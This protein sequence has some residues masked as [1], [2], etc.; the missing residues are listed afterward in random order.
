M[1]YDIKISDNKIGGRQGYAYVC[2]SGEVKVLTA[3]RDLPQEYDDY[4]QYGKVRVV[5]NYRGQE[6]YKTCTLTW[7]SESTYCWKLTSGGTMLSASFGYY[8]LMEMVEDAQSQILR[9]DDVIAIVSYTSKVVIVK[10]YK[11]GRVDIHCSI[12]ASLIELSDEEMAEVKAKAL[13][14]LNR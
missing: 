14:W 6:S 4:K 7:D 11:L 13:R 2:N 9:P 1:K 8:D 12:V 3:N 5:W 10:L